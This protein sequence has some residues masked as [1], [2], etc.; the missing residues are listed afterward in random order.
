MDKLRIINQALEDIQLED[1]MIFDMRESNPFFDFF[2]ITSARNPRQLSAA[3]RDVKA[4][5]SEHGFTIPKVEGSDSGWALVDC[6]DIVVNIFTKEEREYYNLEK[7][8]LDI[9]KIDKD[10]L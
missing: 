5:L 10:R 3:I 6:G 9:P 2:L 7:M 4:A 8:W 1:I